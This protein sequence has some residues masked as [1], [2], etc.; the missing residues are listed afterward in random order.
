LVNY[1]PENVEKIYFVYAVNVSEERLSESEE[2][3]SE[4]EERLSE[5]EERLSESEERLTDSIETR[6]ILQDAVD[7]TR[8][9]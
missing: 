6:D 1:S 8:K 4:S 3:L 5:S 7:A 2:R 9:N